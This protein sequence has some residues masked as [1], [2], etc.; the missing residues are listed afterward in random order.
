MRHVK[1]VLEE[2]R[3][4]LPDGKLNKY[5]IFPYPLVLNT[6]EVPTKYATLLLETVDIA[7]DESTY[8]APPTYAWN[9]GPPRNSYSNKQKAKS[10]YSQETKPAQKSQD[11]EIQSLYQ[12]LSE[13]TK[14]VSELTQ[15][16]MTTCGAQKSIIQKI[17]KSVEKKDDIR[18]KTHVED[19]TLD[20]QIKNKITEQLETMST[21][22]STTVST[23]TGEG[24]REGVNPTSYESNATTSSQLEKNNE[25]INDIDVEKN[26]SK[27][28]GKD[29]RITVRTRAQLEREKGKAPEEPKKVVLSNDPKIDPG[30]VH[31]E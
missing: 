28:K 18:N 25:K 26:N 31:Q 23:I 12:E 5:G 17:Q 9:N 27:P 8:I 3:Q 7:E 24:A 11:K 21:T 1:E 30:V 4:N 13:I 20:T 10:N 14:K 2:I 15:L 22:M 16:M 19:V 6:Y 29:C